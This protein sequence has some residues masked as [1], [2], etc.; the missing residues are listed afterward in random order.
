MRSLEFCA[1]V[2]VP[3]MVAVPSVMTLNLAPAS[4]APDSMSVGTGVRVVITVELNAAPNVTVSELGAGEGRDLID[5]MTV[6]SA[7]VTHY[8]GHRPH[9]SLDQR[10]PDASSSSTDLTGVAAD[11]R[12]ERNEI[13]GGL[14]NEYRFGHEPNRGS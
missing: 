2:G 8:N 1:V 6:L 14:I 9:R 13:R 5:M 4:G 3:E 10:P 11:V 12:V 7:I